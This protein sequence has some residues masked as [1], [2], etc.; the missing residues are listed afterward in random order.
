MLLLDANYIN[1]YTTT[2]LIA[3]AASDVTFSF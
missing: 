1:V 3:T 2:H